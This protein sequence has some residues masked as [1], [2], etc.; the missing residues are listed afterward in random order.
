MG[1]DQW[2]MGNGQWVVRN[3]C[4]MT[5]GAT[6]AQRRNQPGNA[7]ISFSA[8]GFKQIPRANPIVSSS[9]GLGRQERASRAPLIKI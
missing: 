3:A 7:S 1:N 5:N 6:D 9:Q 8:R 4:A 2:A